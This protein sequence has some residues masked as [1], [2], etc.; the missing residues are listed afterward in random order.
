MACL[1]DRDILHKYRSLNGAFNELLPLTQA[2][3]DN[4]FS[5]IYR[6]YFDSVFSFFTRASL[7]N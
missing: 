1:I 4:S 6:S 5:Y 3:I 7:N 2:L